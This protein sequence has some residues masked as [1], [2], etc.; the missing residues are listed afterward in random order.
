MKYLEKVF[1][2]LGKYFA[3]AIPLIIATAIPTIITGSVNDA[4]MTQSINE[5][6]LALANQS[7]DPML[8]LT[9]ML[10]VMQPLFV[11]IGIANIIAF[12]LNLFVVPATYGMINKGLETDNA[13]IG[14]FFPQMGRTLPKYII[15]SIFSFFV[16]IALTLIFALV[17]TLFIFLAIALQ[18]FGGVAFVLA[19]VVTVL[20]GLAL[21]LLMYAI[22][23]ALCYWFPAMIIDNM[24]VTSAFKKS[25][26]VAKS[27]LWQTI[28]ISLLFSIASGVITSVLGSIVGILPYVG[29]ILIS[30]PAA[31]GSFLLSVFY[32]MVYRDKTRE[33]DDE[34]E[35]VIDLPGEYI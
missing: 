25:I 28:G 20:V 10:E 17:L 2:F 1:K 32:L 27:Y 14:D 8:A 15:Y 16:S 34:G 31:L 12:V 18:K 5:L 11:L 24:K 19:I 13:Y 23:C 26:E 35:D 22:N 29:P 7:M 21:Y 33:K 4:E 9:M 3:L 30:I 6:S